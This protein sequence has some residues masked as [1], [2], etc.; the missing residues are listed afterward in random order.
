MSFEN[1]KPEEPEEI[2]MNEVH[3]EPVKR[4][5]DN[6]PDEE[7][8]DFDAEN[9]EDGVE[10]SP[11]DKDVYDY[12][13]NGMEGGKKENF[14]NVK[15]DNP[16]GLLT[17]IGKKF[18]GMK[19]RL[20][21]IA[22][23]LAGGAAAGNVNAQDN[24]F[25][26]LDSRVNMEKAEGKSDSSVDEQYKQ[27]SKDIAKQEKNMKEI[28]GPNVDL[29][30]GKE[31][32]PEKQ[33]K[34][35]IDFDKFFHSQFP[36]AKEIKI[37]TRFGNDCV[38]NVDGVIYVGAASEKVS[39]ELSKEVAE[40]KAMAARTVFLAGNFGKTESFT[41]EKVLNSGSPAIEKYTE[42]KNGYTTFVFYQ[43]SGK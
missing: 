39:Q 11:S 26:E 1:W 8:F 2:P 13:V 10:L 43:V 27:L 22:T 16:E 15:I 18:G 4:A 30:G 25:D 42:G 12:V 9:G 7:N 14:S 28:F 20:L 5:I 32:K 19:S 31:A 41:S 21:I 6:V 35:N 37:T 23:L 17:K 33:E 40:M 24:P 34:I 36:G 38:A 3:Q 29:S